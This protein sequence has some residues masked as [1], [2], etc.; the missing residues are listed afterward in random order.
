MLYKTRV[1]QSDTKEGEMLKSRKTEAFKV[2]DRV[3]VNHPNASYNGETG[4]ISEDVG[5][6]T[7]FNETLWRV[8]LGG[9]RFC[10]HPTSHITLLPAELEEQEQLRECGGIMIPAKACPDLPPGTVIAVNGDG[11]ELGCIEGCDPRPRPC[12]SCSFGATTLCDTCPDRPGY[13][14]ADW[15]PGQSLEVKREWN[16]VGEYQEGPDSQTVI[17]CTTIDNVRH[18]VLSKLKPVIDAHIE[19]L[20]ATPPMLRD[21]R[22][23]GMD[24]K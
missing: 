19:H 23:V 16:I 7:V 22:H 11:R 13:Q 6:S 20:Q 3:R 1:C 15:Q 18:V 9:G 17:T 4:V 5:F 24:V 14:R 8:D 10:V 12:R 21:W 2:G